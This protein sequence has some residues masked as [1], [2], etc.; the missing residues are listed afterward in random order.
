MEFSVFPKSKADPLLYFC[1]ESHIRTSDYM[2]VGGLAVRPERAEKIA[3]E[4]AAIKKGCGLHP[5]MEVKWA[6]C[7][8]RHNSVHIPYVEYM[9]DAIERGYLHLHV[10]LQPFKEYDH[11]K[12]GDRKE[13]DTISKAYYQLLLHRAARYYGGKCRLLVRPDAGDCTAYLPNIVEGLNTDACGTFDLKE[14]PFVDIAP[15]NSK[16]EPMLQ[17]LDVTLGALA[18]ARNGTHVK[19]LKPRKQ[20]LVALVLKLGKIIDIEKS[21]PRETRGFNVWNVVPKWDKGVIPTR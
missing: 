4:L 5:D 12:S 21:H 3:N 15:R 13:T 9:F 14:Q 2:A 10:R 6:K 8:K 1:D 11:R 16:Q 20:E 18:A 19:L 7:K 17:L